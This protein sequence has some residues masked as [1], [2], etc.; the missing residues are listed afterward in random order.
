MLKLSRGPSTR[1]PPS[2]RPAFVVVLVVLASFF[3]APVQAGAAPLIEDVYA[4][5]SVLGPAGGTVTVLALQTSIGPATCQVRFDGTSLPGQGAPLLVYSKAPASCQ[6]TIAARVTV[7]A[8]RA[9]SSELLRF[10]LTVRN[11]GASMAKAFTVTVERQRPW[12]D[13]GAPVQPVASTNW[14]GYVLEG[15]PYTAVTG[16]FQVPLLYPRLG[17]GT[18]TAQWVG[19]DGADNQDLLQAGI[20]E[21]MSNVVGACTRHPQ[22]WA[23]WEELPGPDAPFVTLTVRPGQW[24]TV[25]IAEVWRFWWFVNV[26]NDSTGKSI[27]TQALYFGPRS[28]AE[29]VVEASSSNLCS[30]GVRIGRFVGLR[31]G[32]LCRS[33]LLHRTRCPRPDQT[34]SR[35]RPGT[36]RPAGG[37][38]ESGVEPFATGCP[39]LRR[40][41]FGAGQATAAATPGYRTDHGARAALNQQG[42]SPTGATTG[43]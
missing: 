14:S 15:G 38:S 21:Q 2:V 20:S 30:T 31:H 28:S 36:A 32:G 22:A 1:K 19:V 12:A 9:R 35:G 3:L 43:Q 5:P 10:A 33:S 6:N 40:G 4:I 26:S 39:R 24:V 34:N 25:T 23:W 13:T 17:A 11:A 7:G 8:L 18:R 42:S 27:S 41:L 37:G 16:T 29:W